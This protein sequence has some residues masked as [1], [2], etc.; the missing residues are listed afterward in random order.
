VNEALRCRIA[1][2]AFAL[3]LLFSTASCR[4]T[5]NPGEAHKLLAGNWR[6]VVKSDC[7]HWEV[8]SDTL[9][10]HSDGRMEQHLK[11]L[12]GK[13]YD[14]AHERWEY[15]PDHSVSLD[16]RLTVT[17]P[18]YAGTPQL[19]VLIVEFSQPPVIL[20]N[21]HQN[22]FYERFSSEQ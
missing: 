16:R 20:L 18:Q 14:S 11:L 6:L 8:D 22:C 12:S 17:D 5:P 1:L 4:K 7:A 3:S 9:I 19:E 13:K 2:G 21:P 15:L 10:L